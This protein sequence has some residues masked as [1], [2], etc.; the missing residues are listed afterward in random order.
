MIPLVYLTLLSAISLAADNNVTVHLIPHSHDDVG[1]LKTV[2]GC[3]AGTDQKYQRSEVH[4]ILDE[5]T[6][7]LWE[8]PE[9]TFVEVEMKFFS[10]WWEY[11]TIE[12][13]E[14]V[15]TLVKNG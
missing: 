3:F 2:D 8:D 10:M 6:E 15:R 9:K 4:L 1:W 14:Q 7:A 12:K 5:V 13:K 11:Q